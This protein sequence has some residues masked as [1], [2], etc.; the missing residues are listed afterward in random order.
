MFATCVYIEIQFYHSG[1]SACYL[2]EHLRHIIRGLTLHSM[3]F[4]FMEAWPRTITGLP[5]TSIGYWRPV[6]L[7]IIL[8]HCSD[9]VVNTRNFL[10]EEFTILLVLAQWCVKQI[11]V[12]VRNAISV[13]DGTFDTSLECS[14]VVHKF[15]VQDKRKVFLISRLSLCQY[16]A[17]V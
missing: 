5:P 1:I 7:Y 3:I 12:G 13:E 15:C 17:V 14:I 10:I 6:I 2:A 11:D 8:K 4:I 9:A 16:K